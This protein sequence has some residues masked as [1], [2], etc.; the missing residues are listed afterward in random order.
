MK[1]ITKDAL[2]IP[3]FSHVLHNIIGVD[4]NEPQVFVEKRDNWVEQLLY[5]RDFNE[6]K[7]SNLLTA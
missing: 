6:G 5:Y 7:R 2:S 4:D 1:Q 3:E